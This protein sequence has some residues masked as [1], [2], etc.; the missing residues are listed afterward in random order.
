MRRWLPVVRWMLV[1][2]VLLAGRGGLAA[3]TLLP[4]V[5]TPTADV[6]TVDRHYLYWMDPQK[7][8]S[9]AQILHSPPPW[10]ANQRPS[11]NL[12]YQSQPVWL[13]FD[14][15]N[16]LSAGGDYLLELESPMLDE[17]RFYQIDRDVAGH[18]I[19]VSRDVAGDHYPLATSTWKHRFPLFLVRLSPGVTTS[20][21]L[22]IDTTSALIAPARLWQRDAFF[23]S[24]NVLTF[25]YGVFFGVM[26][27][28]AL[29]NFVLWFFIR[30]NAYLYYVCYVI[31]AMFFQSVMSGY[32]YRYLWNDNDWLKAHAIVVSVALS[33]LFAGAFVVRFLNL[34]ETDP[35]AY[36]LILLGM[37]AYLPL[38]YVA[39]FTSEATLTSIAQPLG[40]FLCVLAVWIGIRQWQRG[41][42][43]AR[44]F[45]LG[46]GV[47]VVGTV[48]Y[49]LML[50]GFFSYNLVTRHLQ[51]I[52]MLAEVVLLS[53]ALA[54]RIN[55]DKQA[56]RIALETSLGL[57]H[58][59]NE[60]NQNQL[61]TQEKMTRELEARVEERT[62]ELQKALNELN[63]ANQQLEELSLTD[64]LTGLHNRRYFD[65]QLEHWFSHSR[66]QRT[67]LSVLVLDV[68]FFKKINDT[69]G[70]LI[71]DQCLKAIA[72]TLHQAALRPDDV[73][74]RYGGEEFVILLQNTELKG[75]R[76]VAERIRLLVEQARWEWDSQR[77]PVTVSIGAAELQTADQ[78]PGD[79]LR[80]ADEALYAAKGGG[81]NRVAVKGG[82]P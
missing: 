32:G 11:L 67:P 72:A 53:F 15:A 2:F 13:R 79:L 12:L 71:G 16:T 45:V 68:D 17:V 70:H 22:R 80:R 21:Y 35:L 63:L 54:A 73:I 64:Q 3:V 41:S 40:L 29:Y 4:S 9:L 36:R 43:P 39:P 58:R 34:R 62:S 75:A 37:G 61:Q 76:Q 5:V 24:D 82:G 46:W 25:Y 51:E 44:F 20:L 81:R 1:F 31:G 50:A 26:A 28:M 30:E 27:V 6:S 10:L 55:E 47:L 48:A 19:E 49:T 66:K 78:Q 8:T 59:V 38:I 69:H 33:Y 74:V 65:Q 52:G 18:L 60:A 77:V 42:L 7:N 57:A 14:V 56:R 23:A